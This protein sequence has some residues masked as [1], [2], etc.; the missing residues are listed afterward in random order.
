MVMELKVMEHISRVTIVLKDTVYKVITLIIDITAKTT[1]SKIHTVSI[2]KVPM[3]PTIVSADHLFQIIM[4]LKESVTQVN[5]P[6]KAAPAIAATVDLVVPEAF[7]NLAIRVDQAVQVI[8]AAPKITR[9]EWLTPPKPLVLELEAISRGRE[10]QVC[11]VL[12]DLMI[13]QV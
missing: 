7:Q 13:F 1:V 8:T 6:T 4:Q 12:M 9:R 10:L 3:V 5:S 11:T 2:P